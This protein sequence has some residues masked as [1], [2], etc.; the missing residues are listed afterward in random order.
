MKKYSKVERG[1]MHIKS[2]TNIS[3]VHKILDR[4]EKQ[5]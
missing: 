2:N 1:F 3:E 4:M 5:D